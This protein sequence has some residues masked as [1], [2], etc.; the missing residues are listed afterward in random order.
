MSARTPN[1]T[2]RPRTGAECRYHFPDNSCS[3][4]RDAT[5]KPGSKACGRALKGS[6]PD[7]PV[8]EQEAML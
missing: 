2:D 3:E 6:N 4:H 1:P 8:V 5:C 7:A